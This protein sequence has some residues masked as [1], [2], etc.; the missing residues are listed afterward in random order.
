VPGVILPEHAALLLDLDGTL[1]DFAPTPDSVVVPPTLL[2]DL[3]RLR[4]ALDDALAIITGRPIAQ[5]DALLGTVPTAVAGE[6]GAA[7]RH[8]P[9]GPVERV[10]L[11][12]FPATWLAEAAELEAALPGILLERKQASFVLHFRRAPQHGPALRA[13]LDAMVATDPAHFFI[14]QAAMAWE[15]K[16]RG[17]DKGT[18]VT[19]LMARAPFAGRVPVFIGDDITDEDGMA[20]ARALGG[21]GLRVQ[22]AFVDPAGVRSW[23][24]RL[25]S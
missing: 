6:H 19:A 17:A 3:T 4:H 7:L 23:L 8:H 9:D 11:P 10:P 24:A 5:V 12:Q 2:T 22:D 14:M 13:A 21:L 20:A 15:L 16:P 18:A 1:I 25:A